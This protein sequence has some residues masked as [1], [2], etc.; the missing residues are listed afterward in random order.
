[1]NIKHCDLLSWVLE[2]KGAQKHKNHAQDCETLISMRGQHPAILPWFLC[3]GWRPSSR[4]VR[5]PCPF[6]P[7]AGLL[8]DDI[9]HDGWRKPQNP[10]FE[11][12]RKRAQTGART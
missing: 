11:V 8:L 4:V 1:M 12:I 10:A 9:A 7:A 5:A 6:R 3:F 2:S